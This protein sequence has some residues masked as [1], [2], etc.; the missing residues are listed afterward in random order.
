[1]PWLKLDD[2]FWTNPKLERLSDKAH[3]LY[4]RGLGYCAQ[5]L[6][7]G[8]LDAAALRTLGA[9]KRLC[10]ELV[11]GACWDVIPDGGYTIH[12][13]LEFNPSRAAVLERRRKEAD[14]K[15]GQRAVANQNP[16]TGRYT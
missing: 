1:M 15:A 14:K 10:D 6:T 16:E 8:V 11:A 7:D 5:H 13:Y 4:M 12:D 3:R 9:P 2:T